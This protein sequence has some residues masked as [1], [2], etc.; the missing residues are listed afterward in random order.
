MEEI[1]KHKAT[2]TEF[3]KQG[4]Y[5]EAVAAYSEGLKLCGGD[6]VEEQY[7]STSVLLLSNR[8]LCL[9]KLGRAEDAL[10][11]ANEATDIDPKFA[12]GWIRRATAFQALGRLKDAL[13]SYDEAI[14]L[15]P[16]VKSFKKARKAVKDTVKQVEKQR[17]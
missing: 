12:K 14:A 3:F 11:D 17:E 6:F 15:A 5:E 9:C 10:K 4:K 2:G 7:L 16:E 8:S 13:A 1:L